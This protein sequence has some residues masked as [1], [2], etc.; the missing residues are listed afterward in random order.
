MTGLTSSGVFVL[1]LNLNFFRDWNRPSTGPALAGKMC[2]I[3]PMEW[4]Y[5]KIELGFKNQEISSTNLDF[6]SPREKSKDLAELF[7]ATPHDHYFWGRVP[8]VS[9]I[10]EM[11]RPVSPVSLLSALTPYLRY[12]LA[13]LHCPLC[14]LSPDWKCLGGRGLSHVSLVSHRPC[15]GCRAGPRCISVAGVGAWPW[16]HSPPLL[17]NNS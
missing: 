3:W 12:H 14:H 13:P 15:D 6:W 11:A 17:W 2:F 9:F 16:G 8:T 5:F 10:K 7:P 1:K 4:F